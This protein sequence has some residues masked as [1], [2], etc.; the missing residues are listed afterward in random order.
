MSYRMWR[1]SQPFVSTEGKR[2]FF[3]LS[4]GAK[5]EKQKLDIWLPEKGDGPFPVIISIHG[6]GFLACDKRNREMIE[7]M[8]SGLLRGYAVVGMNYRLSDE[9]RFPEQ[10]RDVKSCIR[11]LRAHGKKYFL[12]PDSI[13]LWGGSV[14]GYL[15]LMG[16]LC[17]KEEYFDIEEDENRLV[18]AK[19][20]GCVAW[21]P[22]V[23][24]GTAEHQ[25]KMNSI[26][27]RDLFG[28]S[29]DESPEYEEAFPLLH[30]DEFP[31]YEVKDGMKERF[32]GAEASKEDEKRADAKTYLHK[33]MPPIFIQ[34]GSR[35]EIV[36]MQQSLEFALAAE[37]IAG[38]NWGRI[39]II[40]E[41]IH[42]SVLL[43]TKE[44]LKKVFD[45]I[46]EINKNQMNV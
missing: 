19:V 17:E 24:I 18:P 14:G 27:N 42:S 15:A 11:Y 8:L 46:D 10:I 21:Y 4:Y 37:E 3:D 7:P 9:C 41:A 1:K 38:N 23:D 2:G 31:F 33:G 40:P 6:G 35:D 26:I 16:S 36:P 29:L 28:P 44:N 25:L 20:T 30:E 32:L 12:D 22:L 43:E 34:H 45:F 5:S 13:F 39:E